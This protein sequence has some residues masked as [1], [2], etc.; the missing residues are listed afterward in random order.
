MVLSWSSPDEQPQNAS[1]KSNGSFSRIH[2]FANW[3]CMR[4]QR[5]RKMPHQLQSIWSLLSFSFWCIYVLLSLFA[6]S[7]WGCYGVAEQWSI[8]QSNLQMTKSKVLALI[9]CFPSGPYCGTGAPRAA[10][11]N[12]ATKFSQN[13]SKYRLVIAMKKKWYKS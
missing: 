2:I 12:R 4:L 7:C 5:L 8:F 10:K 1:S 6:A 3:V 13:N 11:L 9:W